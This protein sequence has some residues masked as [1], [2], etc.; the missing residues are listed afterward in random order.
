MNQG[1]IHFNQLGRLKWQSKED[2]KKANE[3]GQLDS[4]NGFND[5]KKETGW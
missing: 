5:G 1:W 2:A 3:G 4:V